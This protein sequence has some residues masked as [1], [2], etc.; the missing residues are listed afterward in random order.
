MAFRKDVPV[1]ASWCLPYKTSSPVLDE[2]AV[3]I[4]FSKAFD[5]VPH[6][7]LSIKLDHYGIR[8]DLLK[9]IESF[10][11]N[12]SQEVLFEG[13]TSQSAPVTSGVPQGS[14]LR[15]LFLLYINDIPGSI[16][17]IT[18]LFFASLSGAVGCTSDWR[19]EVAD[20]S[21]TEVG[22]ILSWR[23]IVKYFLRSFSPFR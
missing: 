8:Y 1:K 14:V 13:C 20:S 19:Q 5:K 22:N 21:P 11:S 18:H 15:P 2:D 10:L 3:L 17:S 7:C 4:D 16:A 9:W 23:W 12:R 6:K